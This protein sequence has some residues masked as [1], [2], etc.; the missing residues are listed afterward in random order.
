MESAPP[1]IGQAFNDGIEGFKKNPVMV[2]VGTL[3]YLAISMV[4]A[5]I[6]F[7]NFLFYALVLPPLAGGYII[8]VLRIAKGEE[9]SVED[10]F[11]GFKDYVTFLGAYWLLVLYMVLFGIPAIILIVL[12]FIFITK[13]V[14]VFLLVVG[15]LGWLVIV[16]MF[17]LKWAF[18]LT[19]IA[20]GWN[21]GGIKPA[22]DKS[23]KITEG[24]V[25]ELFLVVLI[26]GL[27]AMAGAIV[28][29][30]G[31]LVTVPISAIGFVAYYL[32]LKKIYLEKT[33]AAPPSLEPLP[34]QP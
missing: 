19:I 32:R 27:F 33:S 8:F 2:I 4:A 16:I 11:A 14:G 30:V 20:D 1:G 23:V 15:Y 12:G 22:F 26:L 24:R 9:P 3:V 28:F 13:C 18:Y 10:L 29:G 7:L 34:P 21:D 25:L 5:W 17:V 31:M 6:P